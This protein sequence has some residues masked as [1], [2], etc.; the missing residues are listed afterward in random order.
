[1]TDIET[2]MN[3]YIE[4]IDDND[5]NR[6]YDAA[7]IEFPTN[8]NIII[9]PQLNE[10]FYKA[11]IH[12]LEHIRI[13]PSFFLQ[14]RK[15]ITSINI[16]SYIEGIGDAAFRELNIKEFIL[17]YLL[18]FLGNYAF[19]NNDK[20]ERVVLPKR[21]RGVG[22]YIFSECP[23]LTRLE[24]PGTQEQYMRSNFYK[25]KRWLQRSSIKEIICTNGIIKIE[26]E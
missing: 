6:L 12:P 26:K 3:K 4:L 23:N 19:S 20:L 11:G 24:Y 10:Y 14:N 22:S 15:E 21:P 5:F 8:G 18:G 25:R 7:R 17:P 9:I 13:I 16:P 2:F 1:M